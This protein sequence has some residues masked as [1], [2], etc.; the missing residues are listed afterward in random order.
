MPK[1]K[2]AETNID[3]AKTSNK[4]RNNEVGANGEGKYRAPKTANTGHQK[5]NP[6]T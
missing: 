6:P 2:L 1:A 4:G 3:N 5:Q